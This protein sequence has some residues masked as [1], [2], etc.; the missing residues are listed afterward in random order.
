MDSRVRIIEAT[1]EEFNE[2]GLKITMDDLAK[3]LGMSKKTL[4]L[5]FNSKEDLLLEVIERFFDEV[6]KREK[7]II[8]DTSMDSVEKIRRIIIDLPQYYKNIDFRK[9]YNL[10]EKYPKIHA[11]L[12][13]NIEENWMNTI[14]L[15]NE[16]ISQ[17]IIRPVNLVVL[18]AMICSSIKAFSETDVL[19]EKEVTYR[20]ALEEMINIIIEGIRMV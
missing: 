7:I 10:E 16:A 15:F 14:E 18:K 5:E 1:V 3:R 6:K 20:E 2:K 4:Y 12:M 19:I 13:E 8:E 17:E 11:K 9:L